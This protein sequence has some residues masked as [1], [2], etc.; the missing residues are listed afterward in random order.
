M[1]SCIFKTRTSDF[2]LITELSIYMLV[3]MLNLF[4]FLVKRVSSYFSDANVAS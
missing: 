4:D 1:F 2:D 3:I